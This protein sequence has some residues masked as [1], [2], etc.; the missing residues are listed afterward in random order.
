MPTYEYECTK[1]GYGFEIEQRITDEPKKRCPD[2][3]GK[4]MRLISGGGGILFKGNGFHVTDYRSE[5]YKKAAAADK[6]K[7]EPKKNGGSKK[8]KTDS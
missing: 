3:R 8:K 5:S 4:V 7:S 1:C 2:C 6:P